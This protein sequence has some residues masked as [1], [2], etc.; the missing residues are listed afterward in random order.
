MTPSKH[1]A[2]SAKES[3]K[4]GALWGEAARPA[5]LWLARRQQLKVMSIGSSFT[6]NAWQLLGV[7]GQKAPVVTCRGRQQVHE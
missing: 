7:G 4:E 1:R 2:R 5:Q 3:R 6:L